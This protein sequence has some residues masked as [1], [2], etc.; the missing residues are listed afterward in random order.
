MPVFD[1]FVELFQPVSSQVWQLLWRL[2]RVLERQT[3]IFGPSFKFWNH[4]LRKQF[5]FLD[6]F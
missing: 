5:Q 3:R 2:E 6:V 4:F 1:V